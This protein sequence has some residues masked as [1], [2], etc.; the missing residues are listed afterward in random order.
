V[1]LVFVMLAAVA[2]AAG[3]RAV[4]RHSDDR[5]PWAGGGGG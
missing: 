5:S 4:L 3:V 1:M 2:I